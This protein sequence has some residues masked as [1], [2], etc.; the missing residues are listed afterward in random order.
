M[1]L[2]CVMCTIII[3]NI[4]YIEEEKCALYMCIYYNVYERVKFHHPHVW[5]REKTMSR[6]EI[7]KDRRRVCEKEREKERARRTIERWRLI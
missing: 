3:C 4:Y 2:T 6:W 5:A 1:K 7:D